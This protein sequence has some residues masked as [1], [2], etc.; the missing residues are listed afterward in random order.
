MNTLFYRHT[1]LLYV[2]LLLSATLLLWACKKDEPSAK[3]GEHEEE[4]VTTVKLVFTSDGESTTFTWKSDEGAVDVEPTLVDTVKLA[5]NT[6]Y[7]LSVKL[8]DETQNPPKDVTAEI[9]EEKEDHLLVFLSEEGVNEGGANFTYEYSDKDTNDEPVGL[10]GDFSTKTT[11]TTTKEGKIHVVLS[12]G[13]SSK[14]TPTDLSKVGGSTDV[15]IK[16][17][18]LIYDMTKPVVSSFSPEMGAPGTMVRISGQNFS[19]MPSENTVT[20]LGGSDESDNKVATVSNATTIELEVTVPDDAQTGPISVTVNGKVGVSSTDFTTVDE[21]ENTDTAPP[22]LSEEDKVNIEAFITKIAPDEGGTTYDF[23]SITDGTDTESELTDF[24]IVIEQATVGDNP[25]IKYTV[26]VPD[27]TTADHPFQND[28][29]GDPIL[30][31][32][33]CFEVTAPDS[34]DVDEVGLNRFYAGCLPA[35]TIAISGSPKAA[36]GVAEDGT[37]PTL[38]ITFQ[39]RA[40]EN[41]R[42]AGSREGTWMLVLKGQ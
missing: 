21:E 16:F 23:E 18:I 17:P 24:S 7:T 20:F 14:D 32:S 31:L 26:T 2:G 11:P 9:K 34:D 3:E 4:L 39:I 19:D 36:L 12:H 22:T 15:D 29:D 40:P 5:T 41:G 35:G 38:T 10:E 8:L 27:P 13:P 37:T 42:T 28:D 6:T 33:G 25:T 1:R 30:P